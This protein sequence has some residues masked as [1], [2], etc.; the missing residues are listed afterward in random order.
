MADEFPL[1]FCFNIMAQDIV[2]K[3]YAKVEEKERKPQMNREKY[4]KKG[5]KHQLKSQQSMEKQSRFWNQTKEPKYFI[6]PMES[7][8]KKKNPSHKLNIND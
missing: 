8:S 3:K 7:T 1:A 2:L 5:T 6:A 4:R